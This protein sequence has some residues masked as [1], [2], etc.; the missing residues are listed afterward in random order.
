MDRLPRVGH[1][2]DP[3]TGQVGSGRVGSGW[4]GSGPD[5]FLTYWVGSGL[6]G[7]WIVQNL[8][9]SVTVKFTQLVNC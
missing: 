6:C 3:S 4:V 2:S 8:T 7:S 5:F 9:L 1:G